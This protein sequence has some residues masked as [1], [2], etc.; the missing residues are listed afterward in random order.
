MPAMWRSILEKC[1]LVRDKAAN[2]ETC[3]LIGAEY[4]EKH[5]PSTQPHD[6]VPINNKPRCLQF[7][8]ESLFPLAGINGHPKHTKNNSGRQVHIYEVDRPATQAWKCQPWLKLKP[9]KSTTK[10]DTAFCHRLPLAFVFLQRLDFRSER[11]YVAQDLDC[12]DCL[13]NLF[14]TFCSKFALFNKEAWP[15]FVPEVSAADINWRFAIGPEVS[16][17][18]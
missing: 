12:A 14:V 5:S 6:L 1:P 7:L 4:R 17:R 13:S 2:L 15:R 9:T 8:R 11:T 3:M 18:E 16:F 10:H